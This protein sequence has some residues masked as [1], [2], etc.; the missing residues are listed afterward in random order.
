[1]S[2]T[3]NLFPPLVDTYTAGFLLQ[4]GQGTCNVKFSLSPYTDPKE[5]KSV[6]VNIINPKNNKSVV[7][8]AI[9]LLGFDL[10][11]PEK[12][13]TIAIG[14]SNISDG[15]QAGQTYKIQLRFCS[16]SVS[17]IKGQSDIIAKAENFSE[18]STP[19]LVT[20]TKSFSFSSSSPSI[21]QNG[22][23]LMDP[24]TNIIS[25]TVSYGDSGEYLD[26]YR[27]IIQGEGKQLYDSGINHTNSINPNTLQEKVNIG[28]KKN[29]NYT[30]IYEFL[31]N[32]LY[33]ARESYNVK[34]QSDGSLSSLPLSLDAQAD[35]EYGR[36]KLII[37]LISG[38]SY[39]SNL[40]I[41]RA[42]H[43]TNFTYWEDVITV[44]ASLSRDNQYVT[45][46]NTIDSGNWYHYAIFKV[47]N[48]NKIISQ[49]IQTEKPAMAVF[50]DMFLNGGG[51]QLRLRFDPNITSYQHTFSESSTQTIGG[52]YPFIKR[53]GNLNYRQIGISGLISYHMDAGDETFISRK[54]GKHNWDV[55]GNDLFTSKDELYQGQ[56][57][58]Y[59]ELNTHSKIANTILERK[60][61][62]KVM[63]FLL[64]GEIKLF[65][66]PTEAPTL[67]RLM[68]VSFTPKQELGRMVY[69]F[70]ATGHEIADCTLDN[71]SKYNIQ[72][73][74]GYKE[75][76]ISNVIGDDRS[77]SFR[78]TGP[79]DY[80]GQPGVTIYNLLD[81]LAENNFNIS[82][83]N[84]IRIQG[85]SS[86]KGYAVVYED[87]FYH[88]DYN[89]TGSKLI[90]Y[91]KK[92]T[93]P[94]MMSIVKDAGTERIN[95]ESLGDISFLAIAIAAQDGS[96][97]TTLTGTVMG[98]VFGSYVRKED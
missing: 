56:T 36:M 41:K 22:E 15:W 73:N 90:I 94:N 47:D 55:S 97:Q 62:E 95:L 24:Y 4:N 78:V 31:S 77:A 46:D 34:V 48:S 12:E 87:N 26:Q 45:Y 50:N 13:V 42:S 35:S 54:D 58:L 40:L 8:T 17:N 59:G 5:V 75:A 68:N 28:F 53:N 39:N 2:L 82:Y 30:F 49:A 61:R 71:I 64:D 69:S 20:P 37:K 70:S 81:S 9:G 80:I 29:T 63:E 67:V 43:E 52:K 84:D 83:A 66:S 91:Y 23:N 76:V 98:T 60:F 79:V 96:T 10:N 93:D 3:N 72:V 44:Q 85:L 74:N 57:G 25:G 92:P 86:Y 51:R 33:A 27:I 89:N 32:N 16:L 6:W 11:N 65:R 1:M 88:I 19:T 18:W 38:L 14:G 7:N 21:N